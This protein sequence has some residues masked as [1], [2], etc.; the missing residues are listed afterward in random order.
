MNKEIEENTPSEDNL[1]SANPFTDHDFP[2]AEIKEDSALGLKSPTFPIVGVGASAGGVD[3][4]Q[5]LFN[6]LPSN[7][8]IAYV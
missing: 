2:D 6:S 7:H 3:A 8:G 1:Q 5:R 4:L